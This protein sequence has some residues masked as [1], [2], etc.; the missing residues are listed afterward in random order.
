MT[1]P[2]V[3]YKGSH[4]GGPPPARIR[5]D[6]E[7]EAPHGWEFDISVLGGGG[8]G[9]AGESHH[10]VT[11]SYRD[12]DMWTGGRVSPSHLIEQVI[13]YVLR[14]RSEPLPAKFDAARVRFWF[15]EFDKEVRSAG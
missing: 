14:K 1:N 6:A 8:Q 5:V 7:R 10:T 15:P 2:H 3:E 11:L 9:S 4:G 13:A 12:H